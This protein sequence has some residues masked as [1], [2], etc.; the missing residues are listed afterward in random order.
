[1]G[2]E[3]RRVTHAYAELRMAQ[4]AMGFDNIEGGVGCYASYD[5]LPRAGAARVTHSA[6]SAGVGRNLRNGVLPIPLRPLFIVFLSLLLSLF[7]CVTNKKRVVT[8]S[9]QF[10]KEASLKGVLA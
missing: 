8:D 7:F 4:K 2:F 9:N 5:A 6:Y 3:L 1:M 10:K